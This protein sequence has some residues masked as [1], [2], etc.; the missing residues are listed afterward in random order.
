MY[1]IYDCTIFFNAATS[2]FFKKG[3]ES[4]LGS[5][6]LTTDEVGP[7]GETINERGSF[8]FLDKDGSV[9]EEGK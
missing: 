4:G 5:L 6:K 1:N 3:M 2:E 9:L 7:I 8:S